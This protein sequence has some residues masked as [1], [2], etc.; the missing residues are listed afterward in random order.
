MRHFYFHILFYV[1]AGKTFAGM[2]Q[3]YLYP[4]LLLIESVTPFNE[5][6]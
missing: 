6:K 3:N 4:P 2:T 5:G 1:Y